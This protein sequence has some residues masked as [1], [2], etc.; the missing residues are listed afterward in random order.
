MKILFL[1]IFS[2]AISQVH[3]YAQDKQDEDRIE[4][5]YKACLGN[6]TSV[7]T[8]CNCSFKAYAKWN[9]QMEYYYKKLL[10]EIPID[11]AKQIAKKAQGAWLTWRDTEFGTY[12]CIFDKEGSMW[13]RVRAEERLNMM[14]ERAQQ[15]RA[16]YEVLKHNKD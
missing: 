16:Y 7:V 13:N 2:I 3:L 5:E 4:T 8:I 9:D 1:I 10:R 14:R 11:T 12:N 6:D 15:L